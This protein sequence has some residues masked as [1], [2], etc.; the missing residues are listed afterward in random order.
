MAPSANPPS[1]HGFANPKAKRPCVVKGARPRPIT[2]GSPR[3]LHPAREKRSEGDVER[4]VGPDEGIIHPQ[5]A[6][7]S[8]HFAQKALKFALVRP[9]Q[10][11]G[12][13][14]LFLE[15]LEAAKASRLVER[16]IL[17]GRIDDLQHADVVAAVAKVFETRHQAGRVIEQIAQNQNQST[18]INPL[19]QVVKDRSE[20]RLA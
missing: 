7:A 18:F 13:G 20:R 12:L 16:E 6:A 11:A 5:V 17:L 1:S 19:R 15:L 4:T 8:A 9:L 14:G 10:R 3:P 2:S